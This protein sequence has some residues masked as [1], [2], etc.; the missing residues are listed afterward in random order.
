MDIDSFI[1]ELEKVC[2]CPNQGYMKCLEK[3]KQ[4]KNKTLMARDLC[5]GVVK[6]QEQIKTLKEEN[7]KLKAENEKLKSLKQAE[8]NQ[9]VISDEGTAKL[10]MDIGNLIGVITKKDEEI[11]KL[12]TSLQTTTS[13]WTDKYELIKEEN[14]K[15]KE[16]NKTK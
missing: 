12:K 8:I 3:V 14:E 7:E 1:D 13:Y 4:L 10:I 16:L 9:A 2:D 6:L 11:N 5:K 15:L